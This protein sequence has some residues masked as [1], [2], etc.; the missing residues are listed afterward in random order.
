MPHGSDEPESINL[1]LGNYDDYIHHQDLLLLLSVTA[2]IYFT[3]PW[4]LEGWE[5]CTAMVYLPADS[6]PSRYYPSP[7]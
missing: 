7:A 6:H 5:L 3:V 2:D 4:R 1:P